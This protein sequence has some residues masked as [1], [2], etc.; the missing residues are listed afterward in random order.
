MPL[1]SDPQPPG[2]C[3][4]LGVTFGQ[5]CLSETPV[6]PTV[7]P[8]ERNQFICKMY[9][10]SKGMAGRLRY[11]GLGE[12]IG[13]P[14]ARFPGWWWWFLMDGARVGELMRAIEHCASST[15]RSG[16]F[17]PRWRGNRRAPQGLGK[18]HWQPATCRWGFCT[19]LGGSGRLLAQ[20]VTQNADSLVY[21][22]L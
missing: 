7:T 3:Q 19:V 1:L 16:G 20:D 21:L 6:Q 11:P 10:I 13:Y 9:A 2:F 15:G 22:S 4:C 17:S 5:S 14:R 12:P 18:P 8:D